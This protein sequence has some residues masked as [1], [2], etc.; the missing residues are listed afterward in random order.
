MDSKLK[1]IALTLLGLAVSGA[2]Y[3]FGTGLHPH[4]WLTWLA[5]IPVL[6]LA[7]RLP[8]WYA[9]TMAFG[10]FVV[11]GLNTFSYYQLVAPLPV[12]FIVL[13]IPAILF[14]A[15]VLLF[16]T[17]VLRGMLFRAAFVVPALWVA[18]EYLSEFKSPHGTF[19]NIAYSQMDFLSVIQIA[20][21]TG[22]WGISFLL[23]LFP[24]AIAALTA[25]A[26]TARQKKLLALV[27][28]T[29]FAA[30][31]GFGVVRLRAQRS[32]PSVTVGLLDTDAKSTMYPQ[33]PAS[34]EL[35]RAYCRHIPD[36]A[37][38]GAQF[39]V[40]PEKL[41]RFTDA[42]VTQ[43]DEML[44]ASAKENH[45]TIA[46]GFHHLPD[47][48]ETRVY[49]PDGAVE[50]VY[51]K[52]HM[53]PAFESEL[54]VGDTRTSLQRASG[55]IGLTICKDMDFPKLSRQYGDDGATLL[56]VPA[57]DFTTDGWLHSR[58]AILRSVESGFSMARAPRLGV[59]T[60]NDDRGRVLAEQNTGSAD[61]DSV[62]ATVPLGAGPTLYDRAGDWFAWFDLLLLA[63]IFFPR[64]KSLP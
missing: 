56:L 49:S 47:R 45:L 9:A 36:L 10:A 4:W 13:L 16:R 54:R 6:M 34:V 62:L 25:P 41:G 60:V 8:F 26:S 64:W 30:A 3:F 14:A 51:E 1:T 24:A 19:G 63:I 31:L 61:F 29:I 18:I 43:A 11:Q 48:N 12:A 15:V 50:A 23:F 33:G 35:I 58:M 44:G 53:L 20:A 17:F 32:A 37:R 21:V 55:K 22:I 5:P 38:Q 40:L 57:W 42:E 46:A 52:H 2:A 27:V 7:S 28:C 59:L 39:V